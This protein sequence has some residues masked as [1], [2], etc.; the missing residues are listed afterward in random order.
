MTKPDHT[1]TL[2]NNEETGEAELI[3]ETETETSMTSHS[4][5]LTI[6]QLEKLLNDARQAM[7]VYIE[8]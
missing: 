8:D 1:I 6:G 7:V 5:F 2:R 3:L 4:I